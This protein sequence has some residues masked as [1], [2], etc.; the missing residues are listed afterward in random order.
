MPVKHGNSVFRSKL[1]QIMRIHGCYCAALA[2][3]RWVCVV[4]LLFQ[5]CVGGLCLCVCGGVLLMIV[6][7]LAMW[8][9]IVVGVVVYHSM[10]T[11]VT[12]SHMHGD[13]LH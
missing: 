2:V 7:V 6:F 9:V 13:M 1:G 12:L 5:Q 8:L 10:M 11:R 3:Q 4:V